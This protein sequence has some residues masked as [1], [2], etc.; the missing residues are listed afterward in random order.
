VT[1]LGTLNI[2]FCYGPCL[3]DVPHS[4]TILVGLF[5][6]DITISG[7]GLHISGLCL[8]LILICDTVL[9]SVLHICSGYTT[10]SFIFLNIKSSTPY[11]SFNRFW[12]TDLYCRLLRLHNLERYD[13]VIHV[14]I[15]PTYLLIPLVF[16][17]VGVCPM[18]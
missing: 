8:V 5:F 12:H 3:L 4:S 18:I 2:P 14:Y 17:G 7:K 16:P 15:P 6:E 10:S 13:Q 1:G 9:K 11:Q